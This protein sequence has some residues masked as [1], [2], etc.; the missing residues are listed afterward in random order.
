MAQRTLAHEPR[1]EAPPVSVQYGVTTMNFP[2]PD[3]PAGAPV[4]DNYIVA[5]AAG[6]ASGLLPRHVLAFGV[7]VD[8]ERIVLRY[9]LRRCTTS[10][11]QDMDDILGEFEALVG[12]EVVVS[13]THEVLET[14]RISP[15]DGVR[16][17]FLARMD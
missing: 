2:R 6:A 17:V 12:P 14:R 7:E 1:S 10:D 4:W 13:S 5:Q 16:W 8:R 11:A 3:D 15:G 9:Q